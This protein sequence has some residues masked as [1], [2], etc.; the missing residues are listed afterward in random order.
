[1]IGFTAPSGSSKLEVL[2]TN[3]NPSVNFAA[4]TITVDLSK[5][6]YCVIDGKI[7]SGTNVD[8]NS[9]SIDSGSIISPIQSGTTFSR[10][11]VTG[12]TGRVV[13]IVSTT[14]VTFGT[15]NY[16]RTGDTSSDYFIPLHIYGL[17]NK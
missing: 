17:I 6:K 7:N 3:P 1:M 8:F 13:S 5:Y 9:P 14:G 2:W 16:M 4:Q 10:W 12:T 11:L 15:G